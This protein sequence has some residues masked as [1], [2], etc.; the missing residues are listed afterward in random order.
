MQGAGDHAKRSRAV[1]DSR[2]CRRLR[3]HGRIASWGREIQDVKQV[4]HLDPE[5]CRNS[6]CDICVLDYREINRLE[7]G[8]F[9][10]IASSVAEG[11]RV[12]AGFN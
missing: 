2:C 8:S 3:C 4:E 1:G 6:L 11:A 12:V 9:E 10:L 7:S 5:L